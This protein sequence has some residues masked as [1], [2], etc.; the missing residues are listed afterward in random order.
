MSGVS[1][2]ETG[3]RLRVDVVAAAD[4]DVLGADGDEEEE[5]PYQ[6]VAQDSGYSTDS[7]GERMLKN[8]VAMPRQV[9]KYISNRMPKVKARSSSK[10]QQKRRKATTEED[11]QE[12]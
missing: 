10:Q 2:Q 8:Y 11:S 4:D 3:E 12:E 9:G 6:I 7:V 5:E 1:L